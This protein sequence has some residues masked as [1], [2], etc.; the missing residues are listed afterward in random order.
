MPK[1][2]DYELGSFN[3]FTELKFL[4]TVAMVVSR[5]YYV[6]FNLFIPFSKEEK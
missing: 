3:Q 2:Y 6:V 5:C 4:F 1:V